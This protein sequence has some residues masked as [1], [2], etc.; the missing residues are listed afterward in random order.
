[1]TYRLPSLNTLRAFEAAARHLS[2]KT[3]ASEL[4][5]TAGAVS[6]QVKKLEDSLGVALF[7]RLPHGLL[8]TVEG[9]TYLPRITKIFEDLTDAT[10]AIAPDM[11]GKKFN[12]GISSKAMAVLPA[13]WPNHCDHLKPYVRNVI[14]TTDVEM[15]RTNEIDCLIR[16]GG[17]PYG[18]LALT[19]IPSS[20]GTTEHPQELHFLCKPGLSDCRQS[21]AL[22]DDLKR[23]AVGPTTGP[24]GRDTPSEELDSKAG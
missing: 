9:E 21:Q 1:M 5:V 22:L 10:E 19:A 3:A 12:V 20:T 13:N 11:N 16:L 2:F 4:G 15:V 6:Q 24:S 7:R 23:F 8:L 18:D 14:Q 17:G